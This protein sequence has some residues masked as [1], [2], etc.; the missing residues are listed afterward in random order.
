MNIKSL[1]SS[2][3]EVAGVFILWICLHYIAA[4]LYPHY[5]AESCVSG[6]IKSIFVAQ[7]PHCIAM[8]WVIYHGGIA[9]N[10]MWIS[11]AIWFSSKLL[12]SVIISDEKKN[13]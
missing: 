3:Y 6:F 12:K 10:S 5:C 13:N 4:N 11:I 8:R 7:A 9:I 1:L 2:L